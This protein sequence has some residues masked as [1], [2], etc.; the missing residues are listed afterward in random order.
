L[1]P[2]SRR[3]LAWGELLWDMFPDGPRLGGAAANVAYHAARLGAEALLV[4]RVGQDELGRRALDQLRR[5]GVDTRHVGVDEERPTGTVRVELE[6]GE[7]RFSIGERVAW[8]RIGWSA[9]LARDVG[10]AD[11]VVFG[12]LAQRSPLG[13]G[14]LATA[15]HNTAPGA[16]RIL[17]LNLRP[18]F[19]SRDVVE[20]SLRRA[21]VVKLNEK[22][23]ADLGELFGA[24][25]ATRWLVEERGVRLVALTLG[26]RGAILCTANERWEHPGYALSGESG[27]TVGAGDAFTAALATLLPRGLPLEALCLVANYYAAFVASCPG[28][29]PPVP[30]SVLSEFR[31]LE[32]LA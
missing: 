32:T 1:A 23:A 20:A 16:W 26:A 9:E 27:D 14:A 15:L 10:R 2:D 19:V 8:D 5:A 12:T 17:D 30:P 28:A 25:D 29:M 7:P 24:R 21:D 11:V 3:V 13:A 4:S 22:E 18:P 6:R 31:R